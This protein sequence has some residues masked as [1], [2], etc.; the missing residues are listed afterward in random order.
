MRTT[1]KAIRVALLLGLCGGPAWAEESFDAATRSAIQGVITKQL[2]AFDRGD[3]AAAEAFAAKGIRDKFP[4]ASAFMAMVHKSYGALIHPKST[5]F[6]SVDPSPHG[7]LQSMTI[8]AADGTV[9]T[10]IY[11]FEQVDGAWRITGCGLERTK[12]Q[13]DI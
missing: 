2:Q 1:G 8:V 4:D 10:A 5:A 3:G 7:P 13:I 11:S 12:G 6:G 9:W